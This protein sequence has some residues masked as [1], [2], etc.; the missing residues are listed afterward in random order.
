MRNLVVAAAI[1]VLPA[2]T[3]RGGDFSAGAVGTTGAAFL[4]VG[5]GARAAAMGGAFVAAAD[6]ASAAY[7]NPAGLIQLK[8]WSLALNH[9]EDPGGVRV[10]NI[11]CAIGGGRTAFG[12]SL[13]YADAGE[14]ERTDA[15]GAG[16]GS[17]RPRSYEAVFSLAEDLAGG[18]EDIGSLSSSEDGGVGVGVSV[19]ALKSKIVEEAQTFAVDAGLLVRTR[20]GE[21][22]MLKAGAA[23]QNAGGRL[24]FDRQSDPLPLTF[25]AG[26]AAQNGGFLLSV[27]GDAPQG[28]AP[29]LA[30]GLE[31]GSEVSKGLK[32]AVR[33]GVNTLTWSD[34][35]PLSA[36]SL[37]G[38][39]DFGALSVDYAL[40]MMGELGQ[41]HRMTVSFKFGGVAKEGRAKKWRS[42]DDET[43]WIETARAWR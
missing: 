28:N 6:D 40:G 37:G 43:Q 13:T 25:R 35:S 36:L 18:F 19:K 26:A 30:L 22:W 27:E 12:A 29:R 7:W 2:G 41:A 3:A 23:A 8:D 38:G 14:I 17:Y 15:N 5:E 21:G 1:W 32:G 24:R 20:M 11:A 9:V 10:E 4:G 42:V 33:A 31:Y 34:V 39:L 16:L